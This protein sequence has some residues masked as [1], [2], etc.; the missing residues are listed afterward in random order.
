MRQQI[1]S[2]RQAFGGT[3]HHLTDETWAERVKFECRKGLEWDKSSVFFEGEKVFWF[4][5]V[6]SLL[7]DGYAQSFEPFQLLGFFSGCVGVCAFTSLEAF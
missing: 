5:V 4:H 3:V 2:G 6:V 7:K 1:L